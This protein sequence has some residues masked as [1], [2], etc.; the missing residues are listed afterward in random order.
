M[1]VLE[2]HSEHNKIV[3]ANRPTR[4]L[5]GSHYDPPTED[6]KTEKCVLYIKQMKI[7]AE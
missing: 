6:L 2:P 5:Q 3:E 7:C 4:Q 1:R